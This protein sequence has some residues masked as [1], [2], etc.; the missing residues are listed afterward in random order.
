MVVITQA[1]QRIIGYQERHPVTPTITTPA[2]QKPVLPSPFQQILAARATPTPVAAPKQQIT[3]QVA[4]LLQRTTQGRQVLA[5]LQSRG[6][7]IAPPRTITPSPPAPTPSIPSIWLPRP[8]TTIIPGATPEETITRVTLRPGEAATE[9]TVQISPTEY[10]T[11]TTITQQA[12]S[13]GFLPQ[14]ELP[15]GILTTAAQKQAITSFFGG[16]YESIPGYKAYES[17]LQRMDVSAPNIVYATPGTPEYKQAIQM[18]YVPETPETRAVRPSEIVTGLVQIPSAFMIGGGL[19]QLGKALSFA[20]WISRAYKVG[21]LT[22]G[23]ILTAKATTEIAAIKSP[24]AQKFQAFSL[25]SQLGAA[26]AGGGVRLKSISYRSITSP[27]RAVYERLQTVKGFEKPSITPKITQISTKPEPI[28]EKPFK[29][30]IQPSEPLK[31]GEVKGV[32]TSISTPEPPPIAK[33]PKTFEQLQWEVYRA[34]GGA[35]TFLT[36]A[37]PPTT[38]KG[39]YRIASTWRYTPKTIPSEPTPIQRFISSETTTRFR[40]PERFIKFIESVQER[41]ARI[42]VSKTNQI[43]MSYQQLTPEITFR[44]PTTEIGLRMGE[45]AGVISKLPPQFQLGKIPS[46]FPLLRFG[47]TTIQKPI[48]PQI[49]IVKPIITD[50][51]IQYPKQQEITIPKEITIPDIRQ[52]IYT[53]PRQIT[54]TVQEQK[55][56]QEQQQKLEQDR[57]YEPWRFPPEPP[58]KVPF[59]YAPPRPGKEEERRPFYRPPGTPTYTARRRREFLISPFEFE[60]E[61]EY[62]PPAKPIISRTK[63]PYVSPRPTTFARPITRGIKTGFY[64][65]KMVT[66]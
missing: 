58:T 48:Q 61:Q 33:Y 56:I 7:T 54:D 59:I 6:V 57:Y 64:K 20:P 52:D 11:T 44:P 32:A 4:T 24:T 45:R 62:R 1:Q 63:A 9:R 18:G 14:R 39:F 3:P 17:A 22:S 28:I 65:P 55:Q 47:T 53:I 25:L 19:T 10:K 66:F 21:T 13:P 27:F 60:P 42:Q 38:Y 35:K 5:A 36:E 30:P 43:R 26:A 51:T 31:V 2:V 41:Q 49:P 37:K 50:I 40:A 12:A 46:F 23:G 34:K 16:L 29:P 15:H 8:G